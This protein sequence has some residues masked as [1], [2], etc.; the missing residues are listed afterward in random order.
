MLH[1][2]RIQISAFARVIHLVITVIHAPSRSLLHRRSP[3]LMR[4]RRQLRHLPCA[5]HTI[6]LASP[7]WTQPQST[8]AFAILQF[9]PRLGRSFAV[10]FFC[11]H[12]L[13]LHRLQAANLS[14][15]CFAEAR[16]RQPKQKA[17]RRPPLQKRKPNAGLVSLT[18]TCLSYLL[19]GR[20]CRQYMQPKSLQPFMV[21]LLL[22]VPLNRIRADEK[23]LPRTR[24]SALCHFAQLH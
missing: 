2:R 20:T 14:S 10:F 3:Q 7:N 1:P 11:L 22:P 21:R 8:T 23:I 19:V 4:G 17:L 5:S 15:D 16:R 6:D 18:M 9:K 13:P 24:T 12:S